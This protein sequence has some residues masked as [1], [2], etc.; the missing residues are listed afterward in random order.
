MF[1]RLWQEKRGTEYPVAILEAS[2]KLHLLF[3]QMPYK[4]SIFCQHRSAWTHTHTHRAEYNCICFSF[5]M[6]HLHHKKILLI[7]LYK[8]I[9]IINL[10]TNPFEGNQQAS[11]FTIS[12]TDREITKENDFSI[13]RLSLYL[14]LLCDCI[15][16]KIKG[17]VHAVLT[18]D[19]I[20]LQFKFILLMHRLQECWSG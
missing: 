6:L 18:Q 13:Y 5:L 11:S 2:I 9:N 14:V 1:G 3:R 20:L 17:L 8:I 16:T 4:P 19:E 10:C 15:C 12:P 7:I